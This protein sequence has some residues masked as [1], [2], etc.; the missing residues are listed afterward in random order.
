[1]LE[2][3][4]DSRRSSQSILKEINPEYCLEGT[5][6]VALVVKNLPVNAGDLGSIPGWGRAPGEGNG[7]PLQCSCLENPMDRGAWRATVH[8]V[9]KSWTRLRDFTFTSITA[10]VFP[11]DFKLWCQRILWRVSWAARRSNLLIQKEINP[12]YSLEGL[13]LKLKLQCFGHLMWRANSLQRPWFCGRLKAGG[14]G[15]TEDEMF[16]W[17]HR[18]NWHEFVQTLKDREAWYDAFHGVAKSQTWL[19]N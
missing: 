4:L 5:S 9:A 10:M 19:N 15:D 18:L 8:A 12:K 6:Q 11:V 13:R 16:G 1:M 7:N 17:Y 2:K 3:T 14:K